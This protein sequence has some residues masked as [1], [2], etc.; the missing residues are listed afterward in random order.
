M[1]AMRAPA[2]AALLSDVLSRLQRVSGPDAKGW[3]TALCPFHQDK[4][5]SL[6]FYRSTDRWLFYCH[7]CGARGDGLEFARRFRNEHGDFKQ[8]IDVRLFSGAFA[9]VAP[10][11]RAVRASR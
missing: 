10:A 5:P 11:K 7:A 3:W 6:S 8:V 4:T 1:V 9:P 2:S